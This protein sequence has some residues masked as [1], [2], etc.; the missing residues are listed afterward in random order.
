M[1]CQ[2]RKRTGK[3]NSVVTLF[4]ADHPQGRNFRLP[5]EEVLSE[6]NNLRLPQRGDWRFVT[7]LLPI[8]Q[9]ASGLPG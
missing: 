2:A 9:T 4:A 7:D 1:A 6:S 5:R 8:Y 3:G